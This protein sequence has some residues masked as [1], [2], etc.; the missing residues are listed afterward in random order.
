[1]FEDN[2]LVMISSLQHVLFCERQFALIHVEQVWC[3]NQYTAEGELL[4]ERVD[5]QHHESRR[6]FRQEYSLFVRSDQ[7][8]LIGIC[9]L[10]EFEY[11]AQKNIQNIIPVEFKR[12]RTK[13][14]HVDIVQLCAQALCLEEMLSRS[15]PSGQIYYLQEHRRTDILI[16]ESL[17]EETKA[18]IHRC[19]EIL[20][21]KLTPPAVYSAKKCTNCSLVDL[22]FPEH[23]GSGGMVVSRY[24]SNQIQMNREGNAL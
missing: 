9:D 21:R 2:D 1:M 16:D 17:V 15:V 14:S 23:I 22:C 8:G 4:H 5:V 18:L 3:E 20:T 12:G 13:P 11:D 10:V 6:K 24:I 19:R 7:L